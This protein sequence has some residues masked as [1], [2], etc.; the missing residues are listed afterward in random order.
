MLR[1][2][3]FALPFC[4]ALAACVAPAAPPKDYAFV[5]TW[6]CGVGVFTF[7]PTTYATGSETLPIRAVAEDGRNYTLHFADGYR[8]ALV[9]V[10]EGG[11]TWVSGASGDQ[12]NCRRVN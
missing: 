2:T 3:L 5:G 6:D 10:T 8:I 9:A 7:T 11:L 12:F 4:A 1:P